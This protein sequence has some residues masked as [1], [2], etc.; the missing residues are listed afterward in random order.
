MKRL[1]KREFTLRV[2]N[3]ATLWSK[4][5]CYHRE[6]PLNC[7]VCGRLI[8]DCFILR[9]PE[10]KG[11]PPIGECCFGYF[12][13]WNPDLF[14]QLIASKIWLETWQSAVQVDSGMYAAPA[15]AAMETARERW[16]RAK[17]VAFSKVK[18]Y[19]KQS[20]EKTWLPRELH[21]ALE[22]AKKTPGKTE[23]WYNKH[24][25]VLESYLNQ[26]S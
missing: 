6:D 26:L 9:T 18:E 24:L 19:R 22:E 12:E 21:Y 3:P 1:T 23:L 4:G 10:N 25:P 16:V 2:G 17:H 7:H 20:G 15:R 11:L 14:T 8:Y 13:K 5:Q